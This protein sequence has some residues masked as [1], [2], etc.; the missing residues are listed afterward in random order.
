MLRIWNSRPGL[1]CRLLDQNM[2]KTQVYPQLVRV[3]SE[4]IATRLHYVR[5]DP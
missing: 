2:H 5:E 1:Y 3:K 4:G